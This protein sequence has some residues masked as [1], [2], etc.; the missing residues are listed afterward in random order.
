MIFGLET[1]EV[2]LLAST[3]IST[4]LALYGYN[5]CTY[6]T[7]SLK[8]LT[9]SLDHLHEGYYRSSLHGKQLSA[10]PALVALNRYETEQELLSAVKSISRE[11]YVDPK[12]RS[13]FREILSRDGKV[14]NFV[15]EIYR[16]KT[17]ERIWISENARLVYDSETLEPLYYEGTVREI[18]EEVRH[19]EVQDRLTKLAANLPGGLFQL[20]MDKD[21]KLTVPYMSHS[22]TRLLD[23]PIEKLQTSPRDFFKY[24]H[25]DDRKT[26]LENFQNSA[27]N[28]EFVDIRIRY[29]GEDN[30]ITWLH[31]TATAE[32]AENGGVTW[33]GH[34]ADI[35]EQKTYEEKTVKLAYTDTL[36]GLPKRSVAQD[37]LQ[38]TIASCDRRSEYAAVLFID[39][40]NFKIL[41]D[42]HGH[43]CGD[44]LLIQVA[45]R[46]QKLIR[47]TDLVARYGG[48]E[49]VIIID[50]LGAD[51]SEAKDKAASFA[52]KV[53]N[54]FKDSFAIGPVDHTSSPSIGV[55]MI[56]GEIPSIAEIIKRADNA[57]YQA[58]KNGRNNFVIFGGTNMGSATGLTNYAKDLEGAIERDEF[59]LLFQPQIGEK[60]ILCGAEAF[61]RWNHPEFGVLTPGEFM[62][63]AEKNGNIIQINDWVIDQAINQLAE[64]EKSPATGHLRLSIN[65]GIQQLSTANFAAKLES[66]LFKADIDRKKL[67]F[68]LQESVLNRNIDRVRSRMLEV[69]GCGISFALDDFGI[70]SSSL[71]S[72]NSLPFDQVKIDG[73]L[74]SAIESES[75]TR[76]LIEGILS[77]S[78]ALGLETVAE[79]VSSSFQ[80]KFLREKGCN[81]SQGYFHYPLMDIVSLNKELAQRPIAQKLFLAS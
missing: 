11:W 24:I 57:M 28:C 80:E 42:T 61:I 36:T 12:R 48:D 16:H 60:G 46:L 75:Q 74:I 51:L 49:F 1:L 13:Q 78:K 18:T 31:V 32:Q 71:S 65:L 25:E 6:K 8:K 76:S 37:K 29:L 2:A 10:N 69:K 62:P 66:K 41:N 26:F 44:E 9:E 22:F 7:R 70:G 47:A 33:H 14:I 43:E 73:F 77:I 79:H 21:R 81:I 40:D 56:G 5:Q 23:I 15:S 34:V 72:L 38:V 17:R 67:F 4:S 30:K 27:A 45:K 68:E 3:A 58:K 19:R 20:N 52:S 53:L 55:T 39:L 50:N 64:W 54:S 59:E 35:S 63:T